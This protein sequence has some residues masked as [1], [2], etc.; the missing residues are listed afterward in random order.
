M[1]RLL[2]RSHGRQLVDLA[3]SEHS[4]GFLFIKNQK[5][6]TVL[7]AESLT[8]KSYLSAFRVLRTQ[9]LAFDRRW[10]YP[11]KLQAL[12]ITGLSLLIQEIDPFINDI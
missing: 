1:S 4:A 8:G 6:Q 7:S 3:G 2:T 10:L 11:I 5:E 9:N 12:S